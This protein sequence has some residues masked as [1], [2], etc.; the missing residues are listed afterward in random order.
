[1]K[2]LLSAAMAPAIMAFFVPACGGEV[3]TPPPPPPP[4]PPPPPPAPPSAT[5]EPPYRPEAGHNLAILATAC[6]FGGIWGDAE[7]ENESTRAE[8]SD[9]RCHDVVRRVYGKDDDDHYRQLRALE[10]SV[11][12][13]IAS[14]VESLAKEDA[15]D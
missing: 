12:G 13:D 7:G 15:D 11:V 4:T 1:M 10:P 8:A 9:A 2:T 3:Q 14:K 6:W 5:P